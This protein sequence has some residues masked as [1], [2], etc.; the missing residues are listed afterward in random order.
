M[1]RVQLYGTR[2]ARKTA[3]VFYLHAR[4]HPDS[5]QVFNTKEEA[6]YGHR[7]RLELPITGCMAS[8]VSLSAIPCNCHP[9]QAV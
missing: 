7:E 4:K 3:E 1:V 9:R 8:E 6:D 2:A 5:Y